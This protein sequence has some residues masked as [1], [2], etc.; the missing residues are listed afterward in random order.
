[1]RREKVYDFN[2]QSLEGSNVKKLKKGA[3]WTLK[4]VGVSSKFQSAD[5]FGFATQQKDYM[6]LHREYMPI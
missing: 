5:V 2:H 6:N 4:H 3:P 1:M